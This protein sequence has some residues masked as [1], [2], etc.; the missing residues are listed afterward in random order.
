MKKG[1]RP[2]AKQSLKKDY[3]KPRLVWEEDFKAITYAQAPSC[4][5]TALQSGICDGR[6]YL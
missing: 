1:K 6:P 4:A 3:E 5:K 2:D